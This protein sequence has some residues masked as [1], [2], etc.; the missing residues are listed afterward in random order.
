MYMHDM[1]LFDSPLQN[2][3]S[4]INE[5]LLAKFK[6]V[7]ANYLNKNIKQKIKIQP[8]NIIN[9]DQVTVQL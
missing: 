6:F 8:T 1:S 5:F 7:I 2:Q 4:H 9:K 3:N